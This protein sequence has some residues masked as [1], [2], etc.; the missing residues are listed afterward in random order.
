[1]S[2]VFPI[3][4]K[5]CTLD[6]VDRSVW[7]DGRRAG[8]GAN[9]KKFHLDEHDFVDAQGRSNRFGADLMACIERMAGLIAPRSRRIPWSQRS[10]SGDVRVQLYI[11]LLSSGGRLSRRQRPLL[12]FVYRS[13]WD[14]LNKLRT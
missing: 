7:L 1:M 13:A 4:N 3:A 5:V 11:S 8:V 2:H 6:E 10:P 12:L 9:S 14:V